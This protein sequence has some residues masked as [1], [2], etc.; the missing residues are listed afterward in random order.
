MSWSSAFDE[1][2][3]LPDGRVLRS[4]K[5]ARTPKRRSNVV[6]RFRKPDQRDMTSLD[7]TSV[8]GSLNFE[9]CPPM[10][11]AVCWRSKAWI[12]PHN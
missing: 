2:I 4:T 3:P 10:M 9:R 7:L 6:E 5:T 1:P 12:I 11:L 8:S